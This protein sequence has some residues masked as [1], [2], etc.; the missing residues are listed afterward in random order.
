LPLEGNP[1]A[2]HIQ[3]MRKDRDEIQA[4][5]SDWNWSQIQKKSVVDK[6]KSKDNGPHLHPSLSIKAKEFVAHG[7]PRFKDVDGRNSLANLKIKRDDEGGNPGDSSDSKVDSDTT[8]GSDDPGSG[9]IGTNT[10]GGGKPSEITISLPKFAKD[11]MGDWKYHLWG[12]TYGNVWGD[13]RF[14]KD[15]FTI[16]RIRIDSNAPNNYYPEYVSKIYIYRY[17]CDILK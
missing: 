7:S 1:T 13:T 16:P 10:D 2:H 11:H 9:D 4:L 3:D 5:P 17:L 12:A 6:T 15:R 8:K 14:N